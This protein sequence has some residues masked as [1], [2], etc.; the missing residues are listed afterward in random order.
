MILVYQFHHHGPRESGPVLFCNKCPTLDGGIY[1]VPGQGEETQWMGLGCP[2]SHDL[3]EKQGNPFLFSFLFS[4]QLPKYPTRKERHGIMVF[5]GLYAQKW[6]F[7]AARPSH[8]AH[9]GQTSLV[10]NSLKRPKPQSQ[11]QEGGGS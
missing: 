11:Q 6:L 1:T 4:L 8:T 3:E 5:D 9:E 2:T 10:S 7:Y